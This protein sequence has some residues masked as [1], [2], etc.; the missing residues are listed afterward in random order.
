MSPQKEMDRRPEKTRTK[1][2]KTAGGGGGGGTGST[3]VLVRKKRTTTTIP[4]NKPLSTSEPA[5]TISAATPVSLFSP[6]HSSSSPEEQKTVEVVT[7]R[8]YREMVTG[9][10]R[11]LVDLYTELHTSISEQH[12]WVYI[13][14]FLIASTIVIIQTL[15][16]DYLFS[17]TGYKILF[18]F[19][20]MGMW[21][22]CSIALLWYHLSEKQIMLDQLEQEEAERKEEQEMTKSTKH[23][24]PEMTLLT[25]HADEAKTTTTTITSLIPDTLSTS[26][27][28]FS[29]TPQPSSKPS[30]TDS[31]P[32]LEAR[33]ISAES[34]TK[35]S[36]LPPGPL[37]APTPTPPPPS[38]VLV[39]SLTP[40]SNLLSPYTP[41][42]KYTRGA[43]VRSSVTTPLMHPRSRSPRSPS[44][45]EDEEEDDGPV[46]EDRDV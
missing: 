38:R 30:A 10:S 22:S 32:I 13:F 26:T 18:H 29:P 31:S 39:G 24:I 1:T 20:V 11:R 40:K 3:T 37:H 17:S 45:E 25:G 35:S 16:A 42:T 2:N 8:T 23:A 19:L 4:E 43:V 21:T 5:T 12:L 9:C 36:P 27:A 7:T 41:P 28:V 6:V 14:G 15:A 34:H 46:A 33:L 44:E